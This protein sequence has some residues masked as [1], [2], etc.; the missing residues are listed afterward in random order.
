MPK[1]Y[2]NKPTLFG[3][4]PPEQQISSEV[5]TL[6]I[7][8]AQV[9]QMIVNLFQL[10]GMTA[11]NKKEQ[12]FILWYAEAAAMI[13]FGYD[14]NAKQM[15][16]TKK[17]FR[18]IFGKEE[19]AW[20]N[21]C[22]IFYKQAQ[23]LW[24][25]FAANTLAASEQAASSDGDSSSSDDED[26]NEEDEDQV[27][28]EEKEEEKEDGAQ[29][30]SSPAK[31]QV[32]KKVNKSSKDENGRIT[33]PALSRGGNGVT[34]EHNQALRTGVQEHL[35]SATTIVHKLFEKLEK[36]ARKVDKRG[37]EVNYA[38][39]QLGDRT[40][41]FNFEDSTSSMMGLD[42]RAAGMVK[43]ICSALDNGR[44]NN[45]I[46]VE[47]INGMSR[48]TCDGSLKGLAALV[49]SFGNGES[50]LDILGEP[51]DSGTAVALFNSRLEDS[52]PASRTSFNAANAL[53]LKHTGKT[54]A[55]EGP[56]LREFMQHVTSD[57]KVQQQKT[58]SE[59]KGKGDGK[60]KGGGKSNRR[61]HRVDGGGFGGSHS[62]TATH[63]DSSDD[64]ADDGGRKG[65]KG[66]RL[67]S[68]GDGGGYGSGYVDRSDAWDRKSGYGKSADKDQGG[69]G[70]G[71]GG[72]GGKGTGCF[73]CGGEHYKRDC[74]LSQREV[75]D[76]LTNLVKS[77]KNS[78]HKHKTNLTRDKHP[79]SRSKSSR[80]EKVADESSGS[81]STSS[82]ESESDQSEYED[83]YESHI[84]NMCLRR[85][86]ELK[87]SGASK[88]KVAK[89]VRKLEKELRKF[90]GL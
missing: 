47:V 10:N 51:M 6:P 32:R 88:E 13:L 20:P 45:V 84:A 7:C 35:L 5:E 14:C 48:T 2:G 80:R 17:A 21:E 67:K 83:G 77:K 41:S 42:T 8:G 25:P 90:K 40:S 87:K 61:K 19:T 50:I 62:M 31:Q 26:K 53:L 85:E 81:S 12:V 37:G 79:K 54:G 27:Q 33:F 78:K 36:T 1:Y 89:S 55:Y 65:G 68:R 46:A 28:D 52:C 30:L 15:R 34:S 58:P 74:P 60:G 18:G 63:D 82:S 9:I 29:E 59:S 69:D 22:P 43:D 76:A 39:L 57:K 3:L 11:V 4:L 56:S 23:E 49:S 64:E 71:K 75:D 66:N 70:S 73:R 44:A 72:K 38:L 16:R 24:G 86:K